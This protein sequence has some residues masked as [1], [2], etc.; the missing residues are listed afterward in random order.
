MACYQEQEIDSRRILQF[1]TMFAEMFFAQKQLI[2]PYNQKR[3]FVVPRVRIK[4]TWASVICWSFLR[5]FVVK[6]IGHAWVTL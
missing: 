6:F 4:C 1:D 2:V 5:A 3:S